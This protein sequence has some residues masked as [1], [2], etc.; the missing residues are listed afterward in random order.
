MDEP[1]EVSIEVRGKTYKGSYHAEGDTVTVYYYDLERSAPLSGQP[2]EVV[3]EALFRDLI[4]TEPSTTKKP[5]P[6]MRGPQFK[7]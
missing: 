1:S 6:N 2:A 3:A 4:A 5:T 7:S